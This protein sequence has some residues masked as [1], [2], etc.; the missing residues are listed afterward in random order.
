MQFSTAR[1][2]SLFRAESLLLGPAPRVSMAD[3]ISLRPGSALGV[4]PAA[5]GRGAGSTLSQPSTLGFISRTSVG[6]GGTPLSNVLLPGFS[7]SFGPEAPSRFSRTGAP[8]TPHQRGTDAVQV[9]EVCG[10]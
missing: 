8:D 6:G 5:E 1:A 7:S 4:P 9:W 10:G 2:E 3:G